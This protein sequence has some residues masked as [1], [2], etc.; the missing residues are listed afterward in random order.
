MSQHHLALLASATELATGVIAGELAALAADAAAPDWIKV[1]PAGRVETRDGRSFA[2]DAAA[3]VARFKADAISIPVDLD[4]SVAL[5]ALVGEAGTVA[6]WAAELQARADGLY[7]RVEW[8]EPGK[9]ALAARTHRYVSPTFHHDEAG[10][11]T[12]LHSVAL[13]PA[14]ALAMPAVASAAPQK[15]QPMLKNVAAALGIAESADEAA[16]LTA[17]GTLKTGTVSKA[18]YDQAVTNLAAVTAQKDAA[19]TKLATLAAE[20]H[21]KQVNELLDG[22]LKAKK[23]IPAQREEYAKLCA[24][25]DGLKQVS[26]LLE[27]TPA[28]LQA[29]GLDDRAPETGGDQETPVALAARATAYRTKMAAGGVHISAADAVIAVKGGAK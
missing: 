14:P 27:K 25:A 26:D 9:S 10:N 11:A 15:D 22:A 6:G 8:L 18:L 4:H 13:V 12:W 24:T 16:C 20:G 3:L 29:S 19:E 1:A 28:N 7:A 21:Q 17:I 2:F 5:R 23:I